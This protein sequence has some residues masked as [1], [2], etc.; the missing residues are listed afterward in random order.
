[1]I[2]MVVH[3][4]FCVDKIKYPYRIYELNQVINPIELT[5]YR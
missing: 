5:G 1:M 4:W 2:L 3:Y